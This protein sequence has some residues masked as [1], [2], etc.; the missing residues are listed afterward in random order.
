MNEHAFVELASTFRHARFL[1]R[2]ICSQV[3]KAYP[4]TNCNRWPSEVPQL[5]QAFKRMGRLVYDVAKPIIQ[6]LD[7]LIAAERPGHGS[8]LYDASFEPGS[9]LAVGRLLH[10]YGIQQTVDEVGNTASADSSGN[11]QS[12]SWCG[13]HNDNST[14]TGLV[15][16]LWLDEENGAPVS[17]PPGAGLY[18]EGGDGEQIHISAPADALG[19]QIGEAAQI[20]SG[21]VVHATP[22]MVRG[23][24]SP[25][26]TPLISRETFALFIEPQWDAQ[27]N[28][29]PQ[30]PYEA[31]FKGRA[32][33]KLIP[34]LRARL[35]TVPTLFGDL[36]RD[37]SQTYYAHNN[38]DSR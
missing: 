37:S 22:H 26:G 34:P 13:W 9:R 16:A 4:Y 14:I 3:R 8:R 20:L 29:P 1:S 19:F 23:Y 35:H 28:P 36:L 24:I 21:G 33:S 10:Y 6:R 15:P 2:R 11:V 31:I 38:P 12:D 27:L 5:E 17:A 32:E 18:V 7:A 25:I 30:T